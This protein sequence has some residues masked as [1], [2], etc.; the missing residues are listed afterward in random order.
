[1]VVVV[2]FVEFVDGLAAF[3]V[4][5]AQDAG[6]FE[7]GEDA[8]DR[9]QADVGT[10]FKQH[11]EHVFRRHVANHTFLENVK[12][13]QSRQGGLQACAFQFVDI[14][15]GG[16]FFRWQGDLA[17]Q[18]Q[19]LQWP[20]HI[21]TP[22][23][24]S[25]TYRYA[26]DGLSRFALVGLTAAACAALAACGSLGGGFNSATSRIAGIVTPYKM[27]V[28]QGNFVS[29][30]QVQALQRG[31]TRTQV[32]EVLGTPLMV[33][34]F[35]AERWDYVFTLKRQG[36]APQSRKLTLQF[37]GEQ[38]DKWEGD[39]MPTEAEFVAMLDVKRL[40]TS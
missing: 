36:V 23:L 29:K 21:A 32:K 38:L 35:H 4:A 31:M 28:V 3:K 17:A 14:G 26:T 10:L 13:F 11:A 12:D 18:A 1:M 33:S 24:M 37:Q 15:H 40:R 22:S 27:E 16:S 25:A 2:A 19:P 34:V 30:E 6:L 9:G 7:L 8:V 39:D 20:D 5:A